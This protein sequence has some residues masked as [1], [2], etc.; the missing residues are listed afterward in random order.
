VEKMGDASL[1]ETR[2]ASGNRVKFILG[3]LLIAAAVIYLIATSTQATAQY[4]LTVD[5][6]FDR[7]EDVMDRDVKLSGAVIGETIQYDIENL[8]LHFTIAN[9]PADSD[10]IEAAGGLAEVLH[11]AVSDPNAK[12]LE[13]VYSGPMPD[14]LRHEAQAI[15]TGRLRGD[16]V[17]EADEILLKCPTRYEDEIPSQV[18]EG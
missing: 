18:V 1:P 17:F 4:F 11:H 15:I 9:V 16:G 2:S 14:L 3:G 10:E 5:E 12:R 8:T 13:V 6:L 7:G